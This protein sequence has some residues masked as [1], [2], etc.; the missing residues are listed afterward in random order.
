VC[1]L[2]H[3][4][5]TAIDAPVYKPAIMKR[6]W[7]TT[8]AF[9]LLVLPACKGGASADAVKLIPDEAE[10]IIGLNPKA[11]TA[12]EVY[13][14]MSTELEADADYKEMMS[15]FEGCGLKPTE[16]DAIVVGANQAEEFVVVVVGDGVGEDDNA[17]C[18]IKALQKA[19]GDEEI[20]EVSK[21]DGKKVIE[22]TDAR[23]YLV[24]K[25]MMAMATT[26]WQDKVG[27]LIDG[28][29][30]P[31]IEN[32]KKDL[33]GKVDTKA[34]V[35]FLAQ[36][37]PELAGMAAMAAPEA[38]EVKTAAGTIDLSKGAA[39][40]F[41]AGFDSEDKAKA[42]AEKLQGLFDGVKGEAPKELAG[43]VE[44]VKIEA[45]GSDV[46]I[47]VSASV[48]DITAAKAVAPL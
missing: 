16:F 4:R 35:W 13:K 36:V 6:I 9:S 32:S 29:G 47:S 39:V 12:S 5:L 2:V 31:A 46:K 30:S 10:F 37:P 14:S 26:A 8:L 21:V 41:I 25:D 19:A 42:V 17:V 28:K 48:D 20:A 3:T 44:S 1:H 23:A 24:N 38:A 7:T 43:M 40:N 22:G 34:A 33:Y 11:I 15:T 45:S 18:I 27:E